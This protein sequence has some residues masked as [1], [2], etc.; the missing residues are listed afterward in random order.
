MDWINPPW[1]WAGLALA[2]L[3]AE[4]MVPG[5]FLIWLGVAATSMVPIVWLAGDLS[6]VAQAIIFAVLA[7]ISVGIGWKL[8]GQRGRR[9]GGPMLNQR[10]SQLIGRV[11]PL[12]RAIVNGR[13]QVYIDDAY[14]TVEGPDL[15]EA[16]TVRVV[17]AEAMILRVVPVE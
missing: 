4:A 9:D 16:S 11:L 15:P 2:L 14:W 5:A 7:M 10:S 13:G 8:R 6:I 3:A 17:A 12:S 1:F